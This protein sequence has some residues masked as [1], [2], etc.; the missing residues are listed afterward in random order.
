MPRSRQNSRIR[1]KDAESRRTDKVKHLLNAAY[2]CGSG[3][4]SARF[5]VSPRATASLS[6]ASAFRQRLGPHQLA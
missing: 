1:R 2:D 4:Q 6:S 3:G 5:L